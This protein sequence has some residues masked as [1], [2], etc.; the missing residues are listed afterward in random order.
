MSRVYHFHRRC[1]Y[2]FKEDRSSE[3]LATTIFNER[4]NRI[5]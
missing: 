1:G 4:V 5:F 3:E 2:R